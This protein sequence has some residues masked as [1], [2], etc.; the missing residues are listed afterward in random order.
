ML[1][2][3]RRLRQRR[4]IFPSRNSCPGCK[5]F[6]RLSVLLQPA[7]NSLAPPWDHCRRT[8]RGDALFIRNRKLSSATFCIRVGAE[9]SEAFGGRMFGNVSLHDGAQPF[10]LPVTTCKSRPVTLG[11][12]NWLQ[13]L[14]TLM[15][16][17]LLL[18]AAGF[19]QTTGNSSLSGVVTD[20]TGAVVP[21]ATVEI[22]N[23]ISQYTRSTTTDNAGQFSFTNIPFNPYHLAVTA[24]G[25][26]AYS[27]DVDVRSAVPLN[28][29]VALQ[30]QGSA[31][32]RHGRSR[33]P[34]I[35]WKT[36]RRFTPTSTGK[37]SARF[38]WKASP[39]N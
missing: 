10:S 27:Q 4:S 16:T 6:P 32:K 23:P 38:P 31:R 25:F 20:P 26:G 28:L 39:R 33:V 37:C 3:R 30:I 11:G 15:V 14:C 18:A 12:A 2:R 19:S 24:T 35:Y 13:Q 22:H 5:S 21:G 36:I 1:R 34:V 8:R 7:S 29:K 17:L 9:D